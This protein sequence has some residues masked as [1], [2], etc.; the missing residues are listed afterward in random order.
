MDRTKKEEALKKINEL[1]SSNDEVR[2]DLEDFYANRERPCIRHYRTLTL[3][4]LLADVY[5]DVSPLFV[6]GKLTSFIF[7][8]N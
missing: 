5:S 8:L 7:I 1:L 6:D 4:S 3:L 2:L